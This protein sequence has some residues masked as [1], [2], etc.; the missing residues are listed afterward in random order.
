MRIPEIL[1]SAI[2][3]LKQR[4]IPRMLRFV[5][6]HFNCPA[7]ISIIRSIDYQP[8][9]RTAM[10]HAIEYRQA[11]RQV[12]RKIRFGLHLLIYLVVNGALMLSHELHHDEHIW[13]F[14]PLVGWGIGLL[15]HGMSVLLRAPNAAWKLRMIEKELHKNR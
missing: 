3:T 5:A 9:R 12:E 1:C 4:F 10:Q 14:G 11:E 6:F 7:C 8:P 2:T 13:S 15:F